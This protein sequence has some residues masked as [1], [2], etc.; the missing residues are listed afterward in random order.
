MKKIR[1]FIEYFQY[2]KNPI[3]ALQFKFGIK[4]ECEIKIKDSNC[5]IKLNN[6][7]ALNR[8]MN[9]IPIMRKE[10]YPEF[11][12][13]INDINNNQEITEIDNIKYINI[14]NTNFIETHPNEYAICTEEYFSDDQWDMLNLEN[15]N[16]IDIGANNT[17]TALY[18]AKNGSSVIAFEPVKHIYELGLENIKLNPS[19]KDKIQYINK[20]VG[21]KKGVLNI[22][23]E[24]LKEYVNRNDSYDI[25]V[26]TIEDIINDYNFPYDV[27]KMDCEGCEFEIINNSDLTKFNEIIFEHHAFMVEQDS[28]HLIDKLKSQN[29]KIKTFPCNASAK[30]FE[31]IGIIYAYKQQKN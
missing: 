31:E 28:N 8:L 19:L 13:Y 20:A 17:D 16:I 30:P 7:I 12:E 22:N 26:I 29:F 24:S 23:A 4:K 9:T 5:K 2:L 14:Y 3:E 6:I 27:L 11:L 1:N 18:F 15:R 10:K 25:E 21:A